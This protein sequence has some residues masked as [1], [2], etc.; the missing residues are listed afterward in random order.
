MILWTIYRFI[1]YSPRLFTSVLFANVNASLARNCT[2]TKP[3]WRISYSALRKKN[4]KLKISEISSAVLL[5]IS[6]KKKVSNR[7]SGCTTLFYKISHTVKLALLE[8]RRF[9]FAGQYNHRFSKNLL[10]PSYLYKVWLLNKKASFTVLNLVTLMR[11]VV[12]NASVL[13]LQTLGGK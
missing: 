6:L 8:L 2:Y 12:Q 5:S 7:F 9:G 10:T 4:W 13:P 3:N 1:R 11:F